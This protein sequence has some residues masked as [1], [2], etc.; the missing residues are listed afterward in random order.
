MES[1]KWDLK[2]IRRGRS[3]VSFL[4]LSCGDAL[5]ERF[6]R[7]KNPTDRVTR[8]L[9]EG[10]WI[11]TDDTAMAISIVRILRDHGTIK[12]DELATAFALSYKENPNRGYGPAA[13]GILEQLL[14]RDWREVAQKPFDGQG[15]CGNGS[16]MRVAPV[17]AY[18]SDDYATC[19]EEAAKSAAPTHAHPEAKAGAIAIAIAAA[20]ACRLAE[21][22]VKKHEFFKTVID[23]T[24]E[25]VVRDGV[26]KASS[27]PPSTEIFQAVKILGNGRKVMCQD[28]VPYA[29]WC[30]ERNLFDYEEGVWNAIAC[31]G[32]I[33][34]M[35]AI[36]GG[37]VVNSS[38][39]GIPAAWIERREALNV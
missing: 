38:K 27:L 8:T 32:D 37:I 25:S 22:A 4:G 1:E 19:V 29:I 17:G 26:I 2:T 24:P 11:Y 13:H 9:P 20:F 5:G 23:H 31:R 39:T 3:I 6:F 36:V 16:A 33:D 35:A 18:F 10:P 30:A 15:S 28:T 14:Y 7:P 12:Q 34:T 21:G